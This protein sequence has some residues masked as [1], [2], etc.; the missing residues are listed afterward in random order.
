VRRVDW[1]YADK[2]L[3]STLRYAHDGDVLFADWG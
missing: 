2:P 1:V 3:T